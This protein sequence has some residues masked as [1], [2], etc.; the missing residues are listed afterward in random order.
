MNLR[1]GAWPHLSGIDPVAVLGRQVGFHSLQEETEGRL[2]GEGSARKS[3]ASQS[4]GIIL[5][6]V[7]IIRHPAQKKQA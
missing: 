1:A 5:L 7:R 3:V 4:S 6:H 2:R